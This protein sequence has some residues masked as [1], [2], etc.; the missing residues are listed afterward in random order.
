MANNL[1]GL[2]AATRVNDGIADVMTWGNLDATANRMYA[3]QKQK[4]QQGI[5]EYQLGE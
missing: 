2:N 3:E 4:E 5:K 1:T